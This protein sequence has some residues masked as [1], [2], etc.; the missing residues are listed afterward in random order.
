MGIVLT[1]RPL[2]VATV[3]EELQSRED[4]GV[5]IFLGR[6]RP[7]RGRF[8]TVVALDYEADAPM[9]QRALRRLAAEA[10]SK[11]R[12]RRV[13]LH[14][15]LG[16]LPVGTVSVIVGAAAP[17]RSTAFRA[18]RFLIER[19]KAEVPIWKTDRARPSHRRP[20]RPRAGGAR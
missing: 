2:S 14:H 13:A 12:I 5:V 7:D 1:R 11:F 6:V 17:H 19:L 4:G 20:R 15:R 10:R 9:A 8:G 16:R 3:Y 18:A